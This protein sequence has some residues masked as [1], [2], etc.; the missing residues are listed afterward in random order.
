MAIFSENSYILIVICKGKKKWQLLIK[1]QQS[2]QRAETIFCCLSNQILTVCNKKE[3]LAN[4]PT[5]ETYS[6]PEFEL[7][8][9]PD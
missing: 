8:Q 9:I 2:N 6:H 5:A 1:V 7:L 4:K 3:H